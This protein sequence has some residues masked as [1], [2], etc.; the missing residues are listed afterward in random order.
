MQ[1]ISDA[2]DFWKVKHTVMQL[3]L[4]KLRALDA[5]VIAYLKKN[6]FVWVTQITDSHVHYIKLTGRGG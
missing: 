4:E 3:T 6:E 2:L 1:S 5:P